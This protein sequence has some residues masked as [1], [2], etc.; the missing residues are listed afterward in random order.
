[1]FSS[2]WSTVQNHILN[3]PNFNHYFYKCPDDIPW[4]QWE[5][6][7]EKCYENNTGNTKLIPSDILNTYE[8]ETIFK[9]YIDNFRLKLNKEL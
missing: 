1:M 7:F 5:L 6:D 3:H 2:D 9:N 8:A 4:I